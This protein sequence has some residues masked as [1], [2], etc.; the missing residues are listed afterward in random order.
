MTAS[1]VRQAGPDQ[2]PAVAA[3][4]RPSEGRLGLLLNQQ[5]TATIPPNPATHL[6]G[7]RLASLG[8]Q[9]EEVLNHP[10]TWSVLRIGPEGTDDAN[11]S[12]ILGLIKTYPTA[13]IMRQKADALAAARPDCRGGPVKLMRRI[14]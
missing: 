14:A 3:T 6:G 11:E 13:E 12:Y 2:R 1:L 7:P 10:S 4:P 8:A 5:P 9:V